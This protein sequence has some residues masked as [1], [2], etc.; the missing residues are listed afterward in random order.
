MNILVTGGAGFIGSH[1]AEAFV[2][3]G[4]QVHVLDNFTSGRE[5]N[6]PAGAV[7]HRMD[8]RDAEAV[9]RLWAEQQFEVLCHHAAQMDVRRSVADPRFDAD[10]NLQGFLTLMEAGRLHGLKKVLFASTGGAIYGDPDY[11]PQDE[12]HPLRPLSPYGI[13][14]LCTERYLYFYQ[15]TY[16]ID[17]VALRY[18]NIY[19][20]RQNPHGEAGVVAIFTEKLLHGQQPVINGDGLQTRDYVF[21][22]DVVRANL[23]ALGL[24]GSGVFN[25]GTGVETNVVELFRLIRDQID[26]TV[27]EHHAPGKPG[28]QRRS[29]LG[30]QQAQE[31]LGWAPTVTMQQGIEATVAWFQSRRG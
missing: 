11:T 30:W 15:Q 4:H 3:Q 19:G 29:V 1:V 14:K 25:I 12:Q 18:A 28:E 21:V 8:I 2:S 9:P 22:A 13:T 20:P 23:A 6:V 17:Y 27:P 16:S 10:V 5:E 26:P 24:E 31:T 7:V